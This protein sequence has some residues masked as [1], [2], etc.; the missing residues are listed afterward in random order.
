MP[1]H[2]CVWETPSW[3]LSYKF[4]LF[5]LTEVRLRVCVAL[6]FVFW[7]WPFWPDE[8]C[9][10]LGCF[11]VIWPIVLVAPWPALIDQPSFTFDFQLN[12]FFQITLLYSRLFTFL[13]I[14][15]PS[16]YYLLCDQ[17]TYHTFHSPILDG[18]VR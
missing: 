9:A 10:W 5:S 2:R 12:L 15:L 18:I 17:V 1:Q 16:V 13:A 6:F 4:Q 3:L 7:A 11:L 14:K 8:F